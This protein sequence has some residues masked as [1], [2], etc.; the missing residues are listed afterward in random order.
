MK[1][2]LTYLCIHQMIMKVEM[3]LFLL[4]VEE[5]VL[6]KFWVMISGVCRDEMVEAQKI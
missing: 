2:T 6:E 3:K 4:V 1:N 5:D